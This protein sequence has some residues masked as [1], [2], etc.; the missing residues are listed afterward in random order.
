MVARTLALVLILSIGETSGAAQSL[1]EQLSAQTVALRA[2]PQNPVLWQA[3]GQL[4]S[5][6]HDPA[7]AAGDFTEAIRLDPFKVDFRL[8]RAR[9]LAEQSDWPGLSPTPQAAL[10]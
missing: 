5:Q 6:L 8:S 4:R 7:G 9:L 2:H 1:D 3:R 10:R